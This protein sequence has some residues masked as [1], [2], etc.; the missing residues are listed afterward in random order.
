MRNSGGDDFVPSS[1]EEE[2][3]P[4]YEYISEDEDAEQTTEDES[5]PS[6]ARQQN[7]NGAQ[8]AEQRQGNGAQN[9]I[10]PPRPS[11]PLDDDLYNFLYGITPPQN[12][13]EV[14]E[15]VRGMLESSKGRRQLEE[16]EEIDREF[17]QVSMPRENRDQPEQNQEFL[18][19][20]AE[21]DVLSR[22]RPGIAQRWR[23]RTEISYPAARPPRP[24]KVP[25]TQIRILPLRGTSPGP[26]CSKRISGT[27][28][29][30]LITA[31][32]RVC[33]N[34]GGEGAIEEGD[35]PTEDEG[36]ASQDESDRLTLSARS[37]ASES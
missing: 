14:H 27:Q 13:R 29:A 24:P 26:T 5:S 30:T 22:Q 28:Y 3:G 7:D 15:E 33:Q 21:I 1:D 36:I 6:R 16:L 32:K 12:Q 2:R 23:I 34:M 35:P 11:V 8:S 4:Q 37:T 31:A 25:P 10:Q 18:G 17:R 9:Q 20:E 19:G